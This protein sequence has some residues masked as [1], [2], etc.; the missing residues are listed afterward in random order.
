M[1]LFYHTLHKNSKHS[2]I[3]DFFFTV[4]LSEKYYQFFTQYAQIFAQKTSGYVTGAAGPSD[5]GLT[6]VFHIYNTMNNP[7]AGGMPVASILSLLLFV[8]ITLV[9]ALNKKLSKLW[10]S[11]DY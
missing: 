8:A 1:V 2:C 4:F 7:G 5:A 9:L 10:V 6:T 3:K 11:Y